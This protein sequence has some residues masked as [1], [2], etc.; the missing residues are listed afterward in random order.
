MKKILIK[1]MKWLLI[2]GVASFIIVEGLIIYTGNQEPTEDVDYLIV[3]G[4]GLYGE[5][6]SPVLKARLNV[7][8]AYLLE[9]DDVLVIVSG[10]QGSNETITEAEAMVKYLVNKGVEVDRIMVE[11]QAT[12]TFEN[13]K[14]SLEMVDELKDVKVGIVTNKFHIFRAMMLAKR[15]ELDGVGFPSQI[16]PSIVIKSYLREYFAFFK[17][18][19]FDR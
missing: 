10:G 5:V 17:S 11:D 12:S 13:L 14:Y 8:S 15:L 18:F 9:H 7:A 2:V 3:L 6:P 1:V 4:A 19:I 16:P